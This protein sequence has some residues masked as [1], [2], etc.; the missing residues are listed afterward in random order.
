MRYSTQQ[1]FSSS[2]SWVCP[3]G[4][5]SVLI[6]AGRSSTS[7]NTNTGNVPLLATVVPNTTYTV[8]I[9]AGNTSNASTFGSI[10]SALLGAQ[11]NGSSGIP[12]TLMWMDG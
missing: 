5:T 6:L 3:A 12:I 10:Y 7:G 2:G 4:V 9:G 11:G 8:T 1:T